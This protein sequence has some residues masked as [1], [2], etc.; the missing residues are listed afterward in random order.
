MKILVFGSN[1]LVGSAIKDFSPAVIIKKNIIHT[2]L[3]EMILIY[4]QKR[5]RLKL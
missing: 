3:Q 2:F 4:C 5:I 1:G